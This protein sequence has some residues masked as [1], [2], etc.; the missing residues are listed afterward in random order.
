MKTRFLIACLCMLTPIAHFAAESNAV[1]VETEKGTFDQPPVPL[2]AIRPQY[3]FEMRR[4]GIGG[5]VLVEFV[6][7][8]EG[9]VRDAKVISAPHKDFHAS[10]IAAVENVRFKPAMKDGRAVAVRMRV[11]LVYQVGPG[12]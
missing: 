4:K 5:E 9:R 1:P 2:S 12:R 3:P 10:A 11:P 8:A 6:V 7:S